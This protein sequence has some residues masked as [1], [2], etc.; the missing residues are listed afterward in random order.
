VFDL[1][2][3]RI[4]DEPLA[5]LA[6]ECGYLPAHDELLRRGHAQAVHLIGRLAARTRL[7]DAD[8]KDAQQEAVLWTLEAIRR[9][10]TQEQGKVQG[11]HFRSF[12]HRVLTARFIDFVR[13]QRRQQTHFPLFGEVGA[14]GT[15]VCLADPDDLAG[16]LAL[17]EKGELRARLERELERLDPSA[18]RLWDLMARGEP[19][20]RAALALAISYDAAKRRRRKLLARLKSS[21]AH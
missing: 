19:L 12:L 4:E 18:R 7:Q 20:R 11:C 21:L 6:Q 8:C 13:H 14:A 5:V 9:Y 2:T 1:D 3:A 15:P 16:P 10:R 17:M